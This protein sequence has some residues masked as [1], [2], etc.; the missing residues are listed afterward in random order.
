MTTKEKMA[1]ENAVLIRIKNAAMR[2]VGRVIPS[3]VLTASDIMKMEAELLLLS[4][5]HEEIKGRK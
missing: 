1:E 3:D 4:R 5:L 2:Y